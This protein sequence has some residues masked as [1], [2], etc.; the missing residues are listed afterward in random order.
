MKNKKYYFAKKTKNELVPNKKKI[1]YLRYII[2][3][4]KTAISIRLKVK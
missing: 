3:F 1:M 4:N 2:K